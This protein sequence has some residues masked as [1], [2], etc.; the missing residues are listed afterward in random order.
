MKNLCLGTRIC[1]KGAN[2]N[3]NGKIYLHPIPQVEEV[4]LDY[5]Y[6]ADNQRILIA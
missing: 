1:L 3:Q 4:K 5:Y 2:I 6:K